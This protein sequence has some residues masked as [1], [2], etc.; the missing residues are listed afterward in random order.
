MKDVKEI[1][2]V[3]LKDLPHTTTIF[4]RGGYCPACALS[5]ALQRIVELEAENERLR[6]PEK[7]S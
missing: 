2:A 4:L 7:A 5:R 6:E 3:A 1:I